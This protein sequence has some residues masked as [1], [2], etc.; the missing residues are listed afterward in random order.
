MSCAI[1]FALVLHCDARLIVSKTS[2][3]VNANLIVNNN[4]EVD[5]SMSGMC[6]GSK[7]FLCTL[8]QDTDGLTTSLAQLQQDTQNL[9]TDLAQT[10]SQL[11][12]DKPLSQVQTDAGRVTKIVRER[13]TGSWSALPNYNALHPVSTD[14][15]ESFAITNG[16]GFGYRY[17]THVII[18]ESPNRWTTDGCSNEIADAVVL[19]TLTTY[20]S[21]AIAVRCCSI[22]GTSGMSPPACPASVTW[23]QASDTCASLGY[24]LCTK[25]EFNSRKTC[26]TGCGFDGS[27]VWTADIAPATYTFHT[28]SDDGSALYV[29]GARIV[30]NDG[31][32]GLGWKSGTIVLG[33]GLHTVVVTYFEKAGGEGLFVN[34]EGPGLSKQDIGMAPSLTLP[35]ATSCK[36]L[37]DSSMKEHKSG[38]YLMADGRVHYCDMRTDGG[39]WT[40]LGSWSGDDN[41]KR[42]TANEPVPG[43]PFHF[44]HYALTWAEKT[45]MSVGATEMVL[46]RST[47]EWLKVVGFGEFTFAASTTYIKDAIAQ[48]S[49]GSLPVLVKVGYTTKAATGGGDFGITTTS[50]DQH[51]PSRYP[52]LNGGCENHL[53]YSYSNG[54][55]DSD[56]SYKASISLGDWAKNPITCDRTEGGPIKFYLAVR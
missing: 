43:N 18:P 21:D 39:G 48:P 9:A 22:D 46:M 16:D 25:A 31:V 3:K 37:A 19:K 30:N 29:N 45:A 35:T 20:S 34:W 11:N 2:V 27:R 7:T 33:A 17:T 28:S 54:V 15:V 23:Q 4:L 5:G 8:K 42:L 6:S 47:G 40:I 51:N 10:Q 38:R 49:V 12:S 50:F 32:H 14:E 56:P 13:F 36:Q 41:E 53:L 52:L 24:R 44:Q 1:L 26:G 55:Y